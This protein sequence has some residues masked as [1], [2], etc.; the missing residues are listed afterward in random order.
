MLAGKSIEAIKRKYDCCSNAHVKQD[1]HGQER[2]ITPSF[3]FT[4]HLKLVEAFFLSLLAAAAGKD[5]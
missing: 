1:T 3:D 2:Q 5:T 4:L